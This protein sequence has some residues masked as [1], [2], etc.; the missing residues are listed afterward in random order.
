MSC[1]DHVTSP[2][3]QALSEQSQLQSKVNELEFELV[4]S[5]Q[6]FSSSSETNEQLT[7]QIE[8]LRTELET[9]SLPVDQRNICN[10]FM[11]YNINY[12]WSDVILDTNSRV[13]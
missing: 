6:Q 10:F 4:E 13:A 8:S 11:W 7:N 9:V 3:C 1:A 2:H 5:Q 12:H